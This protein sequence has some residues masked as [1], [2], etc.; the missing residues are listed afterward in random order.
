MVIC[1]TKGLSNLF[2][3]YTKHLKLPRFIHSSRASLFTTGNMMNAKPPNVL[4]YSNVESIQQEL[5]SFLRTVLAVNE[6]TVYPVTKHQ[7]KARTWPESTNLFLVHGA[8]ESD[9]A[10]EFLDFFLHGGKLMS[11]CSNL[12]SFVLS[13]KEWKADNLPQNALQRDAATSGKKFVT[14]LR[15]TQGA[16]REAQF[17]ELFWEKTNN[18]PS[19]VSLTDL[20]T[21]G[22]AVFSEIAFADSPNSSNLTSNTKS[23]LDFFRDLLK[24]QF[25]IKINLAIPPNVPAYANGYFLGNSRRKLHFLSQTV[26]PVKS[27][28]L[29]LMF[30]KDLT[31]CLEPSSTMQPVLVHET[32][33]DFDTV[34]YYNHLKSSH[35]GQLVIYL[36]VATS[37]MTIIS[38]AELCH[39]FVIIPRQ[40]TSGVGRSK[41][42]WLSPKGCAMF[43]LQMHVPLN[44][45]FGQRLPL[46]QHLVAVAVVRGIRGIANCDK[47][48]IRLK[49]PNDIYANRVVKIGGLII[50]SRFDS[51]QAVVNI[52]CGLN[53]NNSSPTGCIDDL[54]REFNAKNNTNYPCLR[55]E[56]TLALIFN[57]IERLYDAIQCGEVDMQH[58]YDLYYENWLHQDIPVTMKDAKGSE[59]SGIVTGIDE[60]GYLLVKT[61]NI[62]QPFTVHP[63]GNSFDMMKGLIIPKYF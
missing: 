16:T 46:I 25:G 14:T 45:P 17:D 15:D 28:D 36:P 24:S 54:I 41:N 13:C 62:A 58:L 9:L 18:S 27:G 44:S 19:V 32:P 2:P 26:N 51:D 57:E 38:H 52:G 40:Q 29:S 53:V 22:K 8:V 61:D 11:V 42:Q 20:K 6:Y 43:S 34:E 39:G 37:A 56:Q 5:V 63:D 21:G 12:Q 1:V 47:L 35:I 48:D 59:M 50:N 23:N 31:D 60:Y 4:I 55:I 49:W 30:C 7:V 3:I 10:E 33:E